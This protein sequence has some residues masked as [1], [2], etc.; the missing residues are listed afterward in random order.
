MPRLRVLA[1]PNPHNLE[2]ITDLVNTQKPY[3]ISTSDFH[4][5]VVANIKE[6]TGPD[7]VVRDSEYFEKEERQDITWS[8][9]VQGTF[10]KPVSADSVLFGNVFD[11]TYKLPKGSST[12]LK[13]MKFL[14][15]NVEYDMSYNG[16]FWALSPLISTM[17]HLSHTRLDSN[18]REPPFPPDK[19]LEDNLDSIHLTHSPCSS[20][21]PP[22][23]S[24]PASSLSAITGA[25]KSSVSKN[26]T[27]EPDLGTHGPHS[28]DLHDAQ[29]RRS[30][31][32]TADH[33]KKITFGPEDLL[34][35]DFCYGYL[36]FSPGLVVRLPGGIS[37][38]LMKHWH[39]QPVNFLCCER[40]KVDL[41]EGKGPE[42]PW[43][44][45]F[46]CIQ[47]QPADEDVATG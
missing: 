6:F 47:I 11:R 12:A 35:L 40:S 39:G 17:P 46:W 21:T 27:P 29:E 30:Y 16:K 44:R 10:Q 34:T 32:Y 9:Q 41:V 26:T 15:P 36:S 25:L 14:D 19:P 23:E 1:G 8:L 2:D 45:V 43:E 22:P 37:F 28:L 3:T 4:G 38:D 5:Q 42:D 20:S 13:L 31:F 33:R 24:K 7:G 18:H